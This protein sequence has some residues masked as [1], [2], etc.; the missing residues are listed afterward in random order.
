MDAPA[1]V[2][3]SPQQPTIELNTTTT[4]TTQQS[5]C[6]THNG[7]KLK[8]T[9]V[10][11]D[12]KLICSQCLASLHNGHTIGEPKQIFT[13]RLSLVDK[14]LNERWQVLVRETNKQRSADQADTDIAT[15]FASLHQ[16]LDAEE[17]R[18]HKVIAE[19][20][21]HI[22]KV[23]DSVYSDIDTIYGVKLRIEATISGA[24][25][26]DSSSSSDATAERSLNTQPD[27]HTCIAKCPTLEAFLE[28]NANGAFN[29]NVTLETIPT[30]ATNNMEDTTPAF[31]FKL[32]GAADN[33]NSLKDS[34][35]NSYTLIADGSGNPLSMS[36][37]LST[38]D[39]ASKFT[40]KALYAFVDYKP[41]FFSLHSLDLESNKWTPHHP[42][43]E[44]FHK[45]LV[46]GND[47][48]AFDG[49]RG[50]FKF[51]HVTKS[52]G[53]AIYFASKE[54]F[55]FDSAVCTDGVRYA[56]IIG[57]SYAEHNI[58][59]KYRS[60]STIVQY[61]VL[62]NTFLEM[63]QIRWPKV[64]AQAF[65]LD[66]YIYI[67]DVTPNAPHLLSIVQY[68]ITDGSSKL[69]FTGKVDCALQSICFDYHARNIYIMCAY[70]FYRWNVDTYKLEKLVLYYPA[71]SITYGFHQRSP[72]IFAFGY[73]AKVNDFKCYDIVKNQWETYAHRESLDFVGKFVAV[74]PFNQVERITAVAEPTT[75]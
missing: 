8:F 45:L 1:I 2:P 65:L 15:Y 75:D 35:A 23:V 37:S 68:N 19:G 31:A 34:I 10:T 57:G 71:K 9:C 59:W 70:S 43:S 47:I 4:V 12:Y 72:K 63:G 40:V 52:W 5:T 27:I 67:A 46:V 24:A 17:A 61:D 39:Y 36:S 28:A 54:R 6:Q 74:Y 29:K 42:I 32:A 53:E 64:N 58:L 73:D 25:T 3:T 56:Y 41:G 26:S 51:D 48:L 7:K 22:A 18:A 60:Q 13:E 38:T 44:V 50:L 55:G 49:T 30:L 14:S 11:C 21:D 66:D 69:V 62:N 33:N 20:R 16:L